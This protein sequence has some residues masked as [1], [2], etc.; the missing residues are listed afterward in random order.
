MTSE[1]YCGNRQYCNPGHECIGNGKC[2]PGAALRQA[3]EYR[4]QAEEYA[5]RLADE[6]RRLVDENAR[7]LAEERAR[8]E[9]EE[10]ATRRADRDKREARLDELARQKQTP[11]C[12]SDIT[13]VAGQ[14][15]SRGPCPPG[16][17]NPFTAKREAA[18]AP[19]SK[20]NPF[21]GKRT[22]VAPL[23]P[24]SPSADDTITIQAAAPISTGSPV[25]EARCRNGNQQEIKALDEQI[26][27]LRRRD[28]STTGPRTQPGPC[29]IR[30]Q[31]IDGTAAY[32]SGPAEVDN[33]NEIACLELKKIYLRRACDCVARGVA[34]SSSDVVVDD[35]LVAQTRLARA[36]REV[37]RRSIRNPAIRR[38]V[39]RASR[40]RDCYSEET[41]KVLNNTASALERLLEKP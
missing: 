28:P 10:V 31:R 11:A 21:A 33:L 39:D 32:V 19:I 4:R 38:W 3:E 18:K 22:V 12:G 5:R 34:F 24:F 27:V 2:A 26:S 14:D 23:P 8:A 37:R 40:V 15:K 20:D 13:G 9:Q 17:A 25:T 6:A 35:A 29:A 7:R 36:Q 16:K 1:R 41:V 30:L